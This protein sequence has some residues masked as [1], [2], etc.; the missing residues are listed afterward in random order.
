MVQTKEDPEELHKIC[1][2]LDRLTL[3]ALSLM[4]EEIDLKITAENSM[5]VGETHL[6]KTRYICGQN[7]VSSLQLPCENSP[8]FEA[9][10]T[11]NF[12]SDQGVM[13]FD[14]EVHKPN[15]ENYVEPLKWFGFMPPQ[16]L[17]FAQNLYR[18]AVQWI[19][20]AANVQVRLAETYKQISQLK[21]LKKEAVAKG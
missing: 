16:N 18:Q 21:V 11:V 9:L 7:S 10:T 17:Q 19:V 8:E 4:Q 6:A 3:D 20:Q 1:D 15:N 12:A 5:M 2:V 14:M 13:Q